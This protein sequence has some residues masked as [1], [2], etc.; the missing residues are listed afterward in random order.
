MGGERDKSGDLG[1]WRGELGG[2]MERR[3]ALQQWSHALWA[4]QTLRPALSSSAA[5]C[6]GGEADL[7]DH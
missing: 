4:Q 5:G 6:E 2:R 7:E 3:G 1:G